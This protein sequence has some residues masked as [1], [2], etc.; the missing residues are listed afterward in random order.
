MSN[1]QYDLGFNA[2]APD[3]GITPEYVKQQHVLWRAGYNAAS[4]AYVKTTND[5]LPT[6]IFAVPYKNNE[7]KVQY[8]DIT[9]VTLLPRYRLLH[10]RAMKPVLN[11]VIKAIESRQHLIK[12][13]RDLLNMMRQAFEVLLSNGFD[14]EDYKNP[15]HIPK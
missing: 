15:Q 9:S 14:L 10:S 12:S 13:H 2:F 8:C 5:G 1:I 6:E 3:N 7:Y 4:A 11:A